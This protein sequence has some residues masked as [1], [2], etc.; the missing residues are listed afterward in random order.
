[1]SD[2]NQQQYQGPAPVR[3]L[4]EQAARQW[5][6]RPAAPGYVPSTGKFDLSAAYKMVGFPAAL[7]LTQLC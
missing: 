2:V 3:Q 7:L 6:V 4:M 5:Q 1:V